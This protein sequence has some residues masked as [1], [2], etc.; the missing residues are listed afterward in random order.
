MLAACLVQSK[1][2][3][4]LLT[5]LMGFFGSGGSGSELICSKWRQAERSKGGLVWHFSKEIAKKCMEHA[6]P[7]KGDR[8]EGT[9]VLMHPLHHAGRFNKSVPRL[10]LLRH[11]GCWQS[12]RTT[13]DLFVTFLYCKEPDERTRVYSDSC[14][15]LICTAGAWAACSRHVLVLTATLVVTVQQL[16]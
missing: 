1:P 4:A 13:M 10:G 6:V 15:P 8:T 9:V 16:L 5:F 3:T 2:C 14:V 11:A 7:H 12:S